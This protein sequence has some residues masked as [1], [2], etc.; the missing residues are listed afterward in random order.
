MPGHHSPAPARQ[1]SAA[2]GSG[3]SGQGVTTRAGVASR[4]VQPSL[5][6][7][8]PKRTTRP[9]MASVGRGT[10]PTDRPERPPPT[11]NTVPLPTYPCRL[12]PDRDQPRTHHQAPHQRPRPHTWIVM[13][14][15]SYACQRIGRTQMRYSGAPGPRCRVALH[16]WSSRQRRNNRRSVARRPKSSFAGYG[17]TDCK[18]G[19]APCQSSRRS[20]MSLSRSA[21]LTAAASGISD[22]SVQIRSLTRTPVRFI[23]LFGR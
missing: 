9:T 20:H 5:T 3:S 16:G 2:T 13:R 17:R 4:Q 18:R 1:S 19:V 11:P 7:T 12:F 8:L 22:F 6:P 23:R 10:T 15:L 21:T 14:C